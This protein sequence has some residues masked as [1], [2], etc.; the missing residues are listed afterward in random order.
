MI[1]YLYMI[2][3][4]S[5]LQK[6]LHAENTYSMN[7]HKMDYIIKDENYKKVNRPCI[8]LNI[9]GDEA[10]RSGELVEENPSPGFK[11]HATGTTG[12]KAETA[13][14]AGDDMGARLEQ[15]ASLPG[16]AEGAQPIVRKGKSSVEPGRVTLGVI[17]RRSTFC[18]RV[19]EKSLS[20]L[21]HA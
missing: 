21:R 8:S 14:F 19:M 6:Q 20:G 7:T 2:A 4:H 18:S 17:P 15:D 16:A 10:S 12:C 13:L 5:I 3:P 11:S 9:F 1:F